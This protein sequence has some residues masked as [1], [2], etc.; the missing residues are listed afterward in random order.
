MLKAQKKKESSKNNDKDLQMRRQSEKA[1]IDTKLIL[2][3]NEYHCKEET[4]K[5]RCSAKSKYTAWAHARKDDCTTQG[6]KK[7]H[8]QVVH[9]CTELNCGKSF[10]CKVNLK[11]HFRNDHMLALHVC[12]I[13]EKHFKS[14]EYMI[15][16][17]KRTHIEREQNKCDECGKA[18]LTDVLLKKHKKERH[19][20]AFEEGIKKKF[21]ELCGENP[22]YERWKGLLEAAAKLGS[23]TL[24]L[25]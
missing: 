2:I 23:T 21:E 11:K 5:F 9:E 10:S 13:C 4:C 18:C 7:R 20:E 6:K 24:G 25:L 19:S 1:K 12:H 22:K 3:D 15:N 8:T 16:H 17:M 14:R